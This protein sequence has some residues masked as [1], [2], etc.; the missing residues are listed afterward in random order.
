MFW[1][2]LN[3]NVSCIFSFEGLSE[4]LNSCVVTERWQGRGSPA[5]VHSWIKTS[6]K[7]EALK[8][9]CPSVLERYLK[10][11][12]TLETYRCSIVLKLKWRLAVGHAAEKE[13]ILTVYM[14]VLLRDSEVC[15][16]SFFQM[17]LKCQISL[18]VC[19]TAISEP[20]PALVNVSR[21]RIHVQWRIMGL[22]NRF[23]DFFFMWTFLQKNAKGWNVYTQKKVRKGKSKIHVALKV[24]NH[25]SLAAKYKQC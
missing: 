14:L 13:T 21:R 22:P 25:D 18:N 2:F 8:L 11:A 7:A 16:W 10:A 20:T 5:F 24:Q 12:R 3:C 4:G 19:F 15:G 1:T 23:P 9:V 17:N 6:L